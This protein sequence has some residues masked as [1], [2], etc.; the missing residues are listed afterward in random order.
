MES[1]I[2][3]LDV[4]DALPAAAALRARSYE[5]L[6]LDAGAGVVDAGCGTGRAVAE[7]AGRGARAVGVDAGAEMIAAARER[8][9][10][11]DFRLG[12]VHRLPLRD[13][14]MAGYRADKVL[15][16]LADA[17]GALREAARVLAPGGRIVLIG[18]DWDTFVI[19]SDD[20][21]LTRAIV[22]ARADLVPDPRV[23]RR[24]RNLLLD[25]GFER[26]DVEVHTAVFTDEAML[27]L[28]TGLAEAAR[29]TGAIS[30]EQHAAWTADQRERARKGR[31]F[32][33]LPLFVAAARRPR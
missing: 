17:P 28:L 31:M 3:I 26:V 24:Y 13:G 14:E 22:H 11:H 12:D 33:A 7:L 19:D 29:D 16:Q 32:L 15:H 1:L 21:A 30:E 23:A 20:P 8:W 18:Q 5:L 10:G 27:P 25:A 4:A 9:P 2:R 6:E